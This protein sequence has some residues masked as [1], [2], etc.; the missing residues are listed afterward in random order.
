MAVP[1]IP[2]L[3]HYP[4]MSLKKEEYVQPED[5]LIGKVIELY[6]RNVLLID[7]DEFTKQWFKANCGVDQVP[8]QPK[9]PTKNLVYHQ[10]PPHNG[11]GSEETTIGCCTQLNPKRPKKDVKKIFQNDMHILR[12]QCKLVSPEPDDENRVFT[13]S[14]FCGDDTIMVYEI[15]DK[16]SGRIGGKF[17]ERQK[18]KNPER[19]DYYQGQDFLIGKTIYLNRFRFQIQSVDEYTEKYM[20]DNAEEFPQSNLQYVINKLKEGAGSFPNLQE[21]AIHLLKSLDTNGDNFIDFNEFRACLL[22]TSPS[23]RDKRQSRMP[24]SA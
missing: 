5:L 13:L 21:Y 17:M 10:I 3:T 6:G 1:K 11:I 19:G 2:V 20:E 22:Y 8:L 14:F 23:P 9:N 7:C 24:S 16:N 15:C 4:G 18:H 12:F